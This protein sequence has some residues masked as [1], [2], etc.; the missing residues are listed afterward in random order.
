MK[1]IILAANLACAAAAWLLAQSSLA[2][3]PEWRPAAGPLATRWA[4]D[5]SPRNALPEYPRPQMIRERWLNLNGLWSYA[6]KGLADPQPET[7][8]G[9]I[10][11]PYP[12]ESALSGVMK[13][14]GE[15]QLLWYRRTFELPAAWRGDRVLLHFGAVDWEAKVWVNGREAGAHRGGY[16]A[17]SFDITRLLAPGPAKQEI[18]VSVFDPTDK[19]DQPRGKQ[20]SKPEGIFYTPA[21]GIWQTVW[22]EPLPDATLKART[23]GAAAAL[24]GPADDAGIESVRVTPDIDAG[25]ARIEV[26]LLGGKSGFSGYY[27]FTKYTVR[28]TALVKGKK[29]ATVEGPLAE[30]VALPVPKAELWTPDHPFLYDLRVELLAGGRAVDSVRSYFG[31]RKISL[32]KD[33]QGRIRILLN[34]KFVFQAGPLDQGFWP[35]GIYTAPTDEALRFDIETMKRLGFNMARKHVKVEPDRWYYWADRLGLLVWQDMPSGFNEHPGEESAK[36]FEL[37]L[38]RMVEGRRN[39]PCIVMWV[40]FNEGW[41]QHNTPE[42]TAFVKQLDPGR[43]V[44]NASGWTDKGVGD[45]LDMHHYPEPESPKADPVR[46][47]VLSE[48]GGLGMRVENHMWQKASWGY[49]GMLSA[50]SQLTRRYA[51]FFENIYTNLVP[52]QGLNA[53][54]Y[55][56]LTDV[57]TE[58]NGLL[59]YD[60]AVLKPDLAI[61]SAANRGLLPKL[62]PSPELVPAAQEDAAE[63]RYVTARPAQGW[64]DSAFNDAGWKRGRAGFGTSGGPVRTEWKTDD[65]WLRREVVLPA[66]LPAKL[67]FSVFHD[68]DVEIYLNGRLAASATGYTTSYV[69]L[70]MSE[71]GRATVK[72]GRNLIAVHCHQTTGGQYIDVGI[73]QTGR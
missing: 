47:S 46:A 54:I 27:G 24:S 48:F 4:K 55:T 57:E 29:I 5:V 45:V 38:R 26:R 13:P 25:V 14:L 1:R 44:D 49:Q 36:Q 72:P 53:A 59:T 60:R 39:H 64:S 52:A 56:Q 51:R 22:L 20:T 61:I 15:K 7:F 2:A 6:V 71:E 18:L 17:I 70:P 11:V 30:G 37:E 35:D 21:S 43:L 58:S 8:P 28:A 9:Q 10:L 33:H 69:T 3:D 66:R 23:A 68:E 41:G 12:I 63:W 73:V 19:G 50:R 62:P 42:L 40:V 31:M 16:D 65:I 34:N 67:E 32:G